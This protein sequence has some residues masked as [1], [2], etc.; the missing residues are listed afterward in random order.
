[1]T[2]CTLMMLMALMLGRVPLA[3]ATPS[4]AF[5]LLPQNFPEATPC[6]VLSESPSAST[7][8]P[9]AAWSHPSPGP[10]PGPRITLSLDVPLGL[11]QILL[12]QARARAAR[13]QAAANAHILAHVGRR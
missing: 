3:P 12:E 9:S 13:E 8:G 6:P 7:T 2:R 5:Q 11:L 4:P 10:R 1:M